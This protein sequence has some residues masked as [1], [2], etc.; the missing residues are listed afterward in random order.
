MLL[1]RQRTDKPEPH[2]AAATK[3]SSSF[4]PVNKSTS[5]HPSPTAS[6]PGLPRGRPLVLTSSAAV[7]TAFLFFYSRVPSILVSWAISQQAFN[8]SMILL[9]DSLETGSLSHVRKI[10]QA[11]VVFRELQ[12]NGI[13]K[14]AGLAVEKLSWGLDQLRK[15]MEGLGNHHCRDR[16]RSASPFQGKAERGAEDVAG[17]FHDTIMGNTGMLLPEEPGLQSYTQEPFAPFTWAMGRAESEATTPN[18]MKQEQEAN[19][20]SQIDLPDYMTMNSPFEIMPVPR[21]PQGSAELPQRSASERYC[22][23]SP[24]GLFQPQRRG[25][26]LASPISLADS[27]VQQNSSDGMI[28]DHHRS[29]QRLS[30]HL[31]YQEPRR[32]TPPPPDQRLVSS[33][34]GSAG[35]RD[36]SG[37]AHPVST[38][39]QH[40]VPG[41]QFRHNSCPSLHHLAT[42]PPHLRT[43]YS[44]PLANKAQSPVDI[45]HYEMQAQWSANH[46]ASALGSPEPGMLLSPMSDQGHNIPLHHHERSLQQQMAY[47]HSLSDPMVATRTNTS[48]A[49]NMEQTTVDQWKRY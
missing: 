18:R 30:P 11:Y 24:Q 48:A 8:S 7:L 38:A 1:N 46:A 10:E 32:T 45:E 41:A 21:K 49:T 2:L 20:D 23:L 26:D 39:K 44:S 27:M 33:L 34:D 5:S 28:T 25:A 3:V 37:C 36:T 22:T 6:M 19:Y 43:T 12:D 42:T 4:R 15:G 35:V 31:H 17:T 9:L 16:R 14:L 47:L 13:H 40:R 29:R